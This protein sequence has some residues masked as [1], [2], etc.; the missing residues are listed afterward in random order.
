M[1]REKAQHWSSKHGLALRPVDNGD[2]SLSRWHGQWSRVGTRML[3]KGP[4]H[5]ALEVQME[6][7]GMG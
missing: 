6:D 1:V 5:W 2:Q 7:W 3:L 4:G